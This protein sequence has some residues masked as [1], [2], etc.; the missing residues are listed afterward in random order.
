MSFINECIYKREGYTPHRNLSE[1]I[2]WQISE[3]E[4]EEA[5]KNEENIENWRSRMDQ[6]Q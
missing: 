4:K 6:L 3:R 1:Q 2:E 5:R